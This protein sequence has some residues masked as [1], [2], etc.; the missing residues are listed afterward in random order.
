MAASHPIY[1]K[2]NP[3]IEANAVVSECTVCYSLN[4]RVGVA[5]QWNSLLNI[6]FCML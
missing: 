6:Y 1:D 2:R 4:A 5:F 3:E